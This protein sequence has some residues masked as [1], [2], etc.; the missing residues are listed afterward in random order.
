MAA[1]M[2]SETTAAAAGQQGVV[3]R[4]PFAML[5]FCGY[6]MGDYFQHWLRPGR[7][8]RSSRRDAAEDLLRQ[9]VPQ[10]RR[11]QVRLARLRREHARA[12]SGWS[13]ASKARRQGAEQ[14]VRHQPALR[15]PELDGPRLHAAAVRRTSSSIDAAAWQAELAAARRAVP[16]ARATTCRAELHARPRRASRQRLAG[17]SQPD[18]AAVARRNRRRRCSDL[19]DA[20][21]AELD[22]LLARTP[23]PLEPLDAV[24]LDGF[25]CGVI[26]QPVLIEPD[27][28][29]PHVFDFDGAA[30]AGVGRRGLARALRRR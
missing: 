5:P 19:T 26:V 16:A 3:R 29:L 6:N 8:A 20:E 18:R 23:E 14:R 24:M 25:L 9:L 13:S 30:A 28:W 22:E 10:G 27:D 17:L 4:D 11:R 7:E 2:G 21:F 1:T 12:A 15:G